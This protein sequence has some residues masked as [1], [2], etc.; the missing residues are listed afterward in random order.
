VDA[1]LKEHFP[2]NMPMDVLLGKPPR[3]HRDVTRVGGA[4]AGR[5]DRHLAG[6]GRA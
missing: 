5:C 3:M 4:P 2:V 6:T 1:A